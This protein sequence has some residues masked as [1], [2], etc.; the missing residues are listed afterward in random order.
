MKKEKIIKIIYYFLLVIFAISTSYFSS[1]LIVKEKNIIFTIIT[2]VVSLVTGGYIF[3]K[4][5][6]ELVS[7]IKRN[8]GVAIL[9][10]L[11][12]LIVCYKYN[13][14]FWIGKKTLISTISICYIMTLVC[15]YI[16]DFIIKFYNRMNNWDKKAYFITSIIGIVVITILY[17]INEG[18]YLQYDKIYSLDSGWCFNKLFPRYNY[19]DIR[20][21][22][23]STI[24]FPIYAILSTIS[25]ILFCGDNILIIAIML[26]FINFQ[27]LLIT[28]MELKQIFNNKY[29][30]IIYMLSFPILLYTVF[31]E[32]YQL[33]TFL[34]VTYVYNL[35]LNKNTNKI[36][37]AS[38][39]GSMPT[40]AFIGIAEFLNKNTIKEKMLEVLKIIAITI[41]LFISLGRIHSFIYGLDEL[42]ATKDRYASCTYTLAQKVISTTK[43]FKSSIFALPSSFNNSKYLWDNLLGSVSIIGIIIFILCIIGFITN[44]QKRY[45][46]ILF[47][48]VMF[49]F[50]L[51]V[52]LNWSIHESPLFSI[53]F[54][55]AII[56]MSIL[57]IEYIMSKLK[58]NKKII[59]T[60]LCVFML[61]IN[62]S[63]IVTIGKVL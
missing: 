61:V 20:H 17:S 53:Y 8:Y 12:S 3:F 24:T 21:P 44:R 5:S 40:S 4:T 38:S 10:V 55:W 16:K 51:F 33:C 32:K 59:Y 1:L 41:V 19:Y 28:A 56:P 7:N 63:T 13:V 18:W 47:S 58:L 27:L 52:G 2:M 30:F 62:V 45:S 11:V 37:I 22:L 9:F 6:K 54:S 48:W 39:F 25:D 31:F 29:I 26:Q 36:L 43:V 60:I 23:L 49:S 34:V 46:K 57:G 35:I 42:A 50:V 14:A 15:Y